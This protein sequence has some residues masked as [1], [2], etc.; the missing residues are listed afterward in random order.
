MLH[1]WE[2][3]RRAAWGGED[4][5]KAVLTLDGHQWKEV[6][7]IKSRAKE[8]AVQGLGCMDGWERGGCR[9]GT[10]EAICQYQADLGVDLTLK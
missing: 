1:R 9:I 10:C 5:I 7:F 4:V 3:P 2:N 8:L 6:V